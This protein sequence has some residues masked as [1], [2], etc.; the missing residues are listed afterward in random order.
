MLLALYRADAAGHR[1]TV[2][3][4]CYASNAPVTT[5]LRWL[6]KLVELKLVR[7]KD[8]PLDARSTY[9]ELE[10]EARTAVH[11]YLLDLWATIYGDVAPDRI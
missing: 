7:R 10:A 4:L 6:E 11:A 5:A 9:V 1:A 3:N 2:T 8:N